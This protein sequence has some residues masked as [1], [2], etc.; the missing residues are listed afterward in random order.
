MSPPAALPH[1]QSIRAAITR[2]AEYGRQQLEAGSGR[3]I[4]HFQ[5]MGPAGRLSPAALQRMR[6]ELLLTMLLIT[7]FTPEPVS[8]T[9]PAIR[10]LASESISQ[11]MA[12][13]PGRILRPPRVFPKVQALTAHAPWG[14]AAFS[15]LPLTL[16]LHSMV[17]RSPRLLS[18]LP[19]RVS[20]TFHPRG[21]CVGS[22]R[23]QVVP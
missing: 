3:P 12:A 13:I 19:I 7:H 10:K 11:P 8:L 20:C 2:D 23:L 21:G 18:I 4:M 6:S 15:K 17:V 5:A 14:P 16:V 9:R 1:L 22:A